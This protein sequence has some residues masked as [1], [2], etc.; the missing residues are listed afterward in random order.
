MTSDHRLIEGCGS[1]YQDYQAG[2]C[3]LALKLIQVSGVDPG[4]LLRSLVGWVKRSET[5][6]TP[7]QTELDRFFAEGR[8]R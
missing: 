6:P 7:L 4:H 2:M 5:H 1:P 8:P 3:D